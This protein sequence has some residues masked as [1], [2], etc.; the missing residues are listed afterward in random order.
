MKVHAVSQAMTQL[1]GA[2]HINNVTDLTLLKEGNLSHNTGR[3]YSLHNYWRNPELLG[4]CQIYFFVKIKLTYLTGGSKQKNSYIGHV[5][6]F[7]Y[8]KFRPL[9]WNHHF[10]KLIKSRFLMYLVTHGEVQN[11]R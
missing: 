11:L 3:L 5:L 8:K 7:E 6:R 1:Q 10:P 9:F 4:K 2:L